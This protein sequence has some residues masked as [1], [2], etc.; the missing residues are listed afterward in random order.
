MD[1]QAPDTAVPGDLYV[2]VEVTWPG[3]KP[4]TFPP[5]DYEVVEVMQ[6]LG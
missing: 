1:W 5:D 6:D 4:Q 3:S 2:E